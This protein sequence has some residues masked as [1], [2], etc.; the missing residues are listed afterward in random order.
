MNSRDYYSVRTGL[1]NPNNE[2]DLK[3]LK[4]LFLIAFHKLENE[5]YFQKYFGYY[6]VDAGDVL[7]EFG[8][9]I[10]SIFFV[11]LKK[12]NLYPIEEKIDIYSEPDLFDVIEFL[13]DHCSKGVDGYYHSWNDCGHHYNSFNDLEGQK[14]YRELI[15]P[16]LKDYSA[17]YKLSDDGEI[18]VL[19][20]AGL[21]NL[22]EADIPSN[23]EENITSKVEKAILKFRRYRST[24][25]DRRDAVREL[26]D[27]FEYLKPKVKKYLNRKDESDIFNLA[28]NFGIRH[29]NEN[30][31]TD[32]DRSIWLSWMFYFYLATIHTLLRIIEKKEH[33]K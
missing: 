11:N 5:G 24:L 33:K 3:V 6:C 27:I 8:G 2:I 19:A 30:Q 20:D 16:F 25:D 15:N 22:I 10:A 18:L 7:G 28:N 29:H 31:K 32:Y 21:S 1:I 17:K 13:H 9:D 4:K 26:S 12:E 14:Y 23:D